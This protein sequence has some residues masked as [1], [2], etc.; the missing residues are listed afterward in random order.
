MFSRSSTGSPTTTNPVGCA[1]GLAN[2]GVI[3]GRGLV[4]NAAVA[5]PLTTTEETHDVIV[6]AV[7]A[8]ITQMEVEML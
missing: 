6:D 4:E 1:A 3:E 2:P 7:D 5:P 8:S